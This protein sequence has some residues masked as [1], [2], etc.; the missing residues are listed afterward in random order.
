MTLHVTVKR[1]LF[2]HS[3]NQA[4]TAKAPEHQLSSGPQ[5]RR[6]ILHSST[7][8]ILSVTEVRIINGRRTRPMGDVSLL[9]LVL[10]SAAC[11][12]NV[13]SMS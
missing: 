10:F 9:A 4:P 1:P 6:R 12:N 3:G 8:V 13:A 5:L 11:L 7:I 2:V